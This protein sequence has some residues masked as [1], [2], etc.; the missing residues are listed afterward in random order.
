M[1]TKGKQLSQQL[2]VSTEQITY[3]YMPLKYERTH[4]FMGNRKNPC[5]SRAN[6]C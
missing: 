5:D 3:Y 4:C 1:P 6:F 2:L